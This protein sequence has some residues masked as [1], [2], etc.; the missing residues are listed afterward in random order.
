[1]MQ[2][3]KLIQKKSGRK[4]VLILTKLFVHFNILLFIFFL[5][6]YFLYTLLIISIN[7]IIRTII[8]IF[9]IIEETIFLL[10]VESVL[11]NVKCNSLNFVDGLIIKAIIINVLIILLII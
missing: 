7:T 9:C 4:E 6:K 5:F 2:H 8:Y 3:F 1:M 10:C 11:H